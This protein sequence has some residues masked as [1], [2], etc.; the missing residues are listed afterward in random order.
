MIN[1]ETQELSFSSIP[2]SPQ[3]ARAV[4]DL[5]YAEATSIQAAAIPFLLDGQ[6][7]IGH[8]STGTGKTAAFGIPAVECV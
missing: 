7:V 1:Q 3:L 4:E 8:S 6:D 5:H 2:L